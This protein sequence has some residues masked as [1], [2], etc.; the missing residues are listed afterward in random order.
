VAAQRD[1]FAV[2]LAGSG[3]SGDVID[4]D[5]VGVAAMLKRL[6]TAHTNRMSAVGLNN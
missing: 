4:G 6:T 3:D 1:S 5:Q 2:L